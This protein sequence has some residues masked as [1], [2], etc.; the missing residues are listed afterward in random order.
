MPMAAG[1]G[2]VPPD[3]KLNPGLIMLPMGLQV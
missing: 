3:W 2:K 1:N